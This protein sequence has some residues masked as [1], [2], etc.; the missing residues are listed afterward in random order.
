MSPSSLG[1]RSLSQISAV[2][3]SEQVWVK[4][5]LESHLIE[6][7]GSLSSLQALLLDGYVTHPLCS[8]FVVDLHVF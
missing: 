4:M 6:F 3:D 7:G 2:S 8:A 1:S 5:T